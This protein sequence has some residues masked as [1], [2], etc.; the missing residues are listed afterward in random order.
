MVHGCILLLGLRCQG[1]LWGSLRG[2][3]GYRVLSRLKLVLA[4]YTVSPLRL[5]E[6]ETFS[7]YCHRCRAAVLASRWVVVLN[8][9]QALESYRKYSLGYL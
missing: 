5:T 7:V 2:F 1:I 4:L 6:Q 8:Y 3:A 9:C